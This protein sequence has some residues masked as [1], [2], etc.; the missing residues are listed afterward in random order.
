MT[1]RLEERLEGW[2]VL[3]QGELAAADVPQSA[4]CLAWQPGFEGGQSSGVKPLKR[5]MIAPSLVKS[6]GF[7]QECIERSTPQGCFVVGCQGLRLG[8]RSGS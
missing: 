6:G 5:F 4:R 8:L 7:A 3:M 1:V 2:P